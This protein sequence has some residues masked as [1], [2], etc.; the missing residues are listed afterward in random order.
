[1]IP[2]IQ[3]SRCVRI[4]SRLSRMVASICE[5][6]SP[7][8]KS[9]RKKNEQSESQSH[10][11]SSRFV[12]E[13]PIQEENETYSSSLFETAKNSI[14]SKLKVLGVGWDREE[15]LLLLDLTSPLET[16]NSCLGMKSKRAILGTTSK[17]YDPLGLLSP[18]IIPLKIIFQSIYKTGWL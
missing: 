9:C 4:C 18:A 5:S 1:M 2:I 12:K 14:T 13:C 11:V 15:D 3:F 8:P 17:L 10:Q 7:T 6:G 16:D